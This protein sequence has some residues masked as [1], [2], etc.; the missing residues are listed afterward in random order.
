MDYF[1]K[2]GYS[3][4]RLGWKLYG[5]Y[6]FSKLKLFN[7]PFIILSDDKTKEKIIKKLKSVNFKDNDEVAIRFSKE[8]VMHLPFFLGKFKL[9]KIAEIIQKERKDYVPFVHG[10]VKTK[11]SA[12]LYYDGKTIFLE[13]WP[14]IGASKNKVFNEHPDLIKIDSTIRIMRYLKN[15]N[16]EYT[17]GLE[18]TIIPF[19]MS[20]LVE[21]ANKIKSYEKKLKELLKIQN[22]LLCDLN[23]E[24]I[25][26][27]NFM[28]IQKTNELDFSIMDN[29]T[30]KFYIVKSLDDLKRY[31]DSKELLFDIPLN[32]NDEDWVTIIN[33]LKNF[34]KIYVKSL[35]MHLSVILR[36]FGMNIEK[37]AI[38]E[39]YEIKEI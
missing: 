32:R 39:D 1:N 13:I 37:G 14:G 17:D 15:R 30:K 12:C 28:G 9:E 20:F 24:S 34:P 29:A 18:S 19:E 7:R 11:F 23:C 38:N 27:I 10:L 31:D 22:P 33:I 8:N 6:E 21:L 35:T 5:L 16:I 4:E 36:E 26:D 25:M 3:P 2:M